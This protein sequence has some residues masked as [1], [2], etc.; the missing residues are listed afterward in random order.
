[1]KYLAI[2]KRTFCLRH[3]SG[4]PEESHKTSVLYAEEHFHFLV[5]HIQYL[6]IF[7]MEITLNEELFCLPLL[8]P[9]CYC[10]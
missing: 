6:G 5:C 8:L 2:G 7:F 4:S 3:L 9:I 1:M 10:N